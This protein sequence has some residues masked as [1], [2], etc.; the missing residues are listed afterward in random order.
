MKDPVAEAAAVAPAICMR[1][2]LLTE[3]DILHHPFGDETGIAWSLMCGLTCP[4]VG[5]STS[6]AGKAAARLGQR[7]EAQRGIGPI[8]PLHDTWDGLTDMNVACV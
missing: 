1:R 5:C 2:R 8:D 4:A 3:E 6:R 7:S